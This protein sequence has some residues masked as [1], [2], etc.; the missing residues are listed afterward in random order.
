M[1]EQ[2]QEW[3]AGHDD[4]RRAAVDDTYGKLGLDYGEGYLQNL[5]DIAHADGLQDA[6]RHVQLLLGLLAPSWKG[7]GASP[8]LEL[9]RSQARRERHAGD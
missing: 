2:P 5:Y 9:A 8:G 6:Y 4:R 7:S 1:A 3:L